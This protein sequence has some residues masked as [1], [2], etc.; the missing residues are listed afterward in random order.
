M[1]FFLLPPK[2]DP[3]EYLTSTDV[4]KLAAI[5]LNSPPSVWQDEVIQNL[6]REHPYIPP[7]RAIVNF[8]K[9]DDAQGTAFGYVGIAGAPRISI[10]VIIRRRELA[11]LDVM[12][13]RADDDTGV[14]QGIGDTSEDKVIPLT[15]E[16]F[17]AALDTGSIGEPVSELKTRGTGYTEDG[18][19]LRLPFRSRT[20]LASVMGSSHEK[21]EE[22]KKYLSESKEAQAGFALNAGSE[23]IVNSWLSAVPVRNIVREKLASQEVKRASARILSS[24]PEETSDFEAGV[25]FMDS[26]R[27]KAAVAF[28]AMDLANPNKGLQKYL[29]YDDGTYGDR[30]EKVASVQNAHTR[31]GIVR[32]IYEKCATGAIRN[33]M[34]VSFVMPTADGKVI[35]APSKIAGVVVH[36]EVITARLLDDMGRS[37]NVMLSPNVKTAFLDTRT[38]T[39]VIPSE[40]QVLAFEKYEA[41]PMAIDKVAA[42]LTADLKDELICKGGQY[43]LSINGEAIGSLC[44]ETKIA[45]ILDQWFENGPALLALAKEQGNIRFASDFAAKVGEVCKLAS[46]FNLYPE[47]AKEAAKKICIPM[48]LAVKLAAAIGLPEGVDSIL[49]AGFLNEDNLSEFVGLGDD[50]DDTVSKLARLLLAIRMGFPGDESATM[51]AMKA[52]QRVAERLKS[53]VQE[54][55]I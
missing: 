40:S 45:A 51:V 9:K 1:N 21:L 55:G 24:V 52:L 18:S 49:G 29:A 34:I 5:R 53:A 41:L 31:N 33:D 47:L 25:V 15:E 11:P 28:D 54:V 7:D 2:I 12:V 32:E 38:A 48:K 42:A 46:G 37:Y 6:I 4:Q 39:W 43:T 13:Q 50:F 36:N 26:G 44:N 19:A 3:S 35:S 30:P 20:A 17:A 14:D 22:F 16:T 10:P 27:T 23:E 8:K